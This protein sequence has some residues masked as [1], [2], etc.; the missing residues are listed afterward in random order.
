MPIISQP[1]SQPIVSNPVIEAMET[2]RAMRFFKPDL[3]PEALLRTVLHAA[4]RASSPNNTQAWTFV[5]VTDSEQRRRLGEALAPFAERVLTMPRP[6]DVSDRR[7]LAGAHNLAAT[8]AD[9]PVIVFVCVENVYPAHAPNEAMM[10]SAGYAASQNLVVAARSL[11][12]GAAFTTMH[13]TA[14]PQV[15]TIL[16]V[17]DDVYIAT[18]IP[19]GWPARSFGPVARK[20]LDE[21]VRHDRW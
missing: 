8:F 2:S 21:V 11:E 7:T 18:T 13:M 3:V 15:R 16:G 6:D 12:L 4:T 14:E 10:L 20:P 5:V 9:V 19:L 17:P 1:M